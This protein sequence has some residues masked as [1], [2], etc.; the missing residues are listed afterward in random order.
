MWTLDIILKNKFQVTYK[1]IS[2]EMCLIMYKLF[3]DNI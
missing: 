1:I 2:R 3:K